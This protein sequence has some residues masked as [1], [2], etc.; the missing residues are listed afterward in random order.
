[1]SK[2]SL[3]LV[4]LLATGLLFIQVSY[5]ADDLITLT[6]YLAVLNSDPPA[7]SDALPQQLI[8]LEDHNGEPLAQIILNEATTSTWRGQEV[9]VT[10]RI[11]DAA[12]TPPQLEV[13]EITPIIQPVTI[14]AEM[15]V[16][17]ASGSQPWVN[18]LCK[19]SDVAAEPY[20]PAQYQSLFS[21]TYPGLDHYWRQI[22]YNA[23]NLEGTWTMPQWVVLPQPRAY[24]NTT[25]PYKV[26]LE[27]LLDDCTSAADAAVD[28]SAYTGINLLFN[29]NLDCCSWGGWRQRTLDGQTRP[30]NVTWLPVWAQK[31]STIA[32]EMGH[33]FGLLHSSG[34]ATQPPLGSGVFVSQ[35]DVMSSSDGTCQVADKI[36]KCIPPGTTAYQMEQAG[37]LPAQRV[38]IIEAGTDTTL[39]LERLREPDSITNYLLVK[40]PINGSSTHFYT[41]EARFRL[42]G[43]DNYD[44][45]IPA[46]AVIIHDVLIGRGGFPG[47]NTGPALVVAANPASGTPFQVVNGDGAIWKEGETYT[48]IGNDIRISVIGRSNSSFTIRVSNA[49]ANVPETLTPVNNSTVTVNPPILTWKSLAQA[50]SYDVQ[51]DTTATFNSGELISDQT[52]TSSYTIPH[53]LTAGRVYY[54][55]VRSH[56]YIGTISGWSVVSSF[57]LESPPDAA[58]ARTAY[59]TT[60]PT[61]TWGAVPWATHY[62]IQVSQQL[63]F[64]ALDF[65]SIVAAPALAVQTSPLTAGVAYYWRVR[66]LLNTD[67]GGWSAVDNFIISPAE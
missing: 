29:D 22:S 47:T 10:G 39:T 62:E 44:Q 7:G 33:G 49:T 5:A 64:S 63:D 50:T 61:L 46:N 40:I 35:W 58:P 55:R 4:I 31:Y 18:L 51:F 52:T 28:F 60:T 30:W 19:F 45:N 38:A 13:I 15:Q 42:L 26:D 41:V 36:F 11:V 32:H 53:P 9:H 27:K 6:G 25:T 2:F 57:T 17:A 48:D 23:V 59:S 37:W 67:A 54:W 34:P 14:Q 24:Y 16:T 21:S 3:R 65:T 1:M 56:A 12:T 8:L 66:A 43:H 20:Q